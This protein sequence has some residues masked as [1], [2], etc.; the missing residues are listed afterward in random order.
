MR[1]QMPGSRFARLLFLIALLPAGPSVAENTSDAYDQQLKDYA[2]V[3][4]VVFRDD[5][6]D[7]GGKAYDFAKATLNWFNVP[8]QILD[9]ADFARSVK[10]DGIDGTNTLTLAAKLF[11]SKVAVEKIGDSIR[12]MPKGDLINLAKKLGVS[13][14]GGDLQKNILELMAETAP[15]A[16]STANE[17]NRRKAAAI[18]LVDVVTKFCKTCDVAHKGYRLAKEAAKAADIAFDNTKTQAIFA[19]ITKAQAD[20]YEDFQQSFV[21]QDSLKSGARKALALIHES[22]EMS[23]PSDD[24]VMKY[25]FQRYQGWQRETKARAEEAELLANVKDKYLN[26]TEGRKQAMFGDGTEED[27]TRAFMSNYADLYRK[28]A[29]L[30]GDKPWPLGGQKLAQR[31]I[32][33]LLQ[34]TLT[35]RMTAGEREYESR[36]LAASWGWIPQSE[37]GNPPPSWNQKQF[38]S[39]AEQ[40]AHIGDRLSKLNYKKLMSIMDYMHVELP[41]DFMRCLCSINPAGTGSVGY[42]KTPRKDC[43]GPCTG[44]V[45]N[46]VSWTPRADAEG[47]KSCMGSVRM[48]DGTGEGIGIDEYLAKV[49]QRGVGEGAR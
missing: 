35:Q 40:L 25:I 30:K 38:Q 27:W 11:A 18:I 10:N 49:L 20:N 43:P 21:G 34:K 5:H 24:E 3:K 28:V 1:L 33:D 8:G 29:G 14:K 17:G 36:R 32:F 4:Q 23:P 37:V 22:R 48:S 2:K 39:K 42:I 45:I 19:N 44:G 13:S 46:C 47:W 15:N 7:V 31:K 9:V 26:L 16:A 12:K 41:D 6:T